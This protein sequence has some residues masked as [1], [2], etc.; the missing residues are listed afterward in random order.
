MK[1]N[2][3]KTVMLNSFQHLHLNQTLNKE[4]EILNQVQDD[5]IDRTAHGFTLIELLVVVLIIGILAAVAV[6]QYQKAVYKSRLA[7]LKPLVQALANTADVYYLANGEYPTQFNELDIDLPEPPISTDTEPDDRGQFFV[8]FP[9]GKC[10][11]TN[12]ENNTFISC[13]EENIAYTQFFRHSPSAA[14]QRYCSA[15]NQDSNAFHAC[16]TETGFTPTS[17]SDDIAFPYP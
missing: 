6:P 7:K 9:W 10:K 11:L 3:I 2:N 16:F 17:T 5:N 15:L 13:Y 1:T 8:Y 4:E 14:G 12:N